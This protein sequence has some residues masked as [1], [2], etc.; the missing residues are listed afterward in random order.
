MLKLSLD[1]SLEDE[2][3]APYFY[4]EPIQVETSDKLWWPAA[5]SWRGRRYLVSEV[6]QD[7]QDWGFGGSDIRKK[8]WR[9]RHHRN[10][11]LVKTDSGEVFKIYYDRGT[12]SDSRREWILLTREA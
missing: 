4:C 6:I 2:M 10:Y 12:K 8:T 1:G 11:F 7:W 5:F 3:K 9:S